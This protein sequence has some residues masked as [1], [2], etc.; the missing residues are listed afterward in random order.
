MPTINGL[1]ETP[2]AHWELIIPSMLSIYIAPIYLKS[3]WAALSIRRIIKSIG[4]LSTDRLGQKQGK[5]ESDQPVQI[6]LWSQILISKIWSKIDQNDDMT[7]SV[8]VEV[9]IASAR[10]CCVH[11]SYSVAPL[12]M[13]YSPLLETVIKGTLRQMGWCAPT[14]RKQLQI[15]MIMSSLR[16]VSTSCARYVRSDLIRRLVVVKSIVAL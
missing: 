3:S 2:H 14:V 11:N 12:K 16:H 7:C 5:I 15:P 8:V 10:N 4:R 13:V 1:K 6:R 9:D